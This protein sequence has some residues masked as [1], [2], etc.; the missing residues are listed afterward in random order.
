MVA[1]ENI[2]ELLPIDKDTG[3]SRLNHIS[4]CMYADTLEMDVHLT[5]LNWNNSCSRV[6]EGN[7]VQRL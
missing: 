6:G 5:R 2:V 3:D 4:G 1:F 7:H